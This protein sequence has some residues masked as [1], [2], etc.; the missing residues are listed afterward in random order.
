MVLK[1]GGNSRVIRFDAE[2]FADVMYLVISIQRSGVIVT[3][4]K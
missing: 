4:K 2:Q 3:K 1:M